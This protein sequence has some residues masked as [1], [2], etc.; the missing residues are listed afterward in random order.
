MPEAP[1]NVPQVQ[2]GGQRGRRSAPPPGL[3][4]SWIVWRGPAGVTF[5]PGDYTPVKDGKAVTTASFTQ[6]GDYVLRARATDGLA[7]VTQDIKLTVNGR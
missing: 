1:V 2:R 6:P 4:I 3:S 7:V 5:D